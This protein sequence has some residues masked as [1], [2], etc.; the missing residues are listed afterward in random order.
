MKVMSTWSLKPGATRE[1][2]HRFL[3]GEAAPREGVTLHDR[4]H[5]VDISV[6]FS[7]YETNNSAALYEGAAR[8]A[9][10]LDIRTYLVVEDAEAGA[11]MA[12]VFK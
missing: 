2:V 10:F 4:W 9:E 11:A 8:W 1:A 3:A 6:G 5:S 12:R 7:L